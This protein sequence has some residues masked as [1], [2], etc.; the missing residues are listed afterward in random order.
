MDWTTF[1]IEFSGDKG[2]SQAYTESDV[3]VVSKTGTPL[4]YD[5]TVDPDMEF[6]N[7]EVITA[8]VTVDDRVGNAMTP[9]VWSF[10][11]VAEG[12]VQY[13]TLHPSGLNNQ[14]QSWTITSSWE[15]DLDSND[16]DAT[17]ATRCC[18]GGPT[19]YYFWVDMDDFGLPGATIQSMTIS[20]YARYRIQGGGDTPAVGPVNIGYKTGS[21][22]KWKGTT[23]TNNSLDYT[24]I[25]FTATTDSENGALDPTDLDNL[26]IGVEKSIHSDL[27]LRV[28]EVAVEVEYLP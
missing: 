21:Y 22:S 6:G 17:R 7:G 4:S 16:G 2:Y 25:Q 8:T 26:Q 12:V 13:M 27:E 1:S 20:V 5:I 10:T 24:L 19:M 14:Y 3:S 23:D 28:T 9:A 11:T 15:T 18:T